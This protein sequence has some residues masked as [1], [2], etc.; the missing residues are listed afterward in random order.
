MFSVDIDGEPESNGSVEHH[1]ARGVLLRFCH[2]LGTYLCASDR[3]YCVTLSR[4]KRRAERYPSA[5]REY[6]FWAV[7]G[8]AVQAITIAAGFGYFY[9]AEQEHQ[10]IVE[11][12]QQQE[13]RQ[14][15]LDRQS[16]FVRAVGGIV[17]TG[18]F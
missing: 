16:Y 18:E 11:Q 9:A 3:I 6:A 10:R 12:R 1:G 2:R 5:F 13:Q 15:E 8:L 17:D 4:A 7:F 14:R